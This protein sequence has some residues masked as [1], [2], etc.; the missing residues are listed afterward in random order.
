M[1]FSVPQ[2]NE[3]SDKWTT[4]L[5]RLEAFFEGN[6]VTDAVQ[7]RALLVSALSSKTIEV[8]QASSS[9]T[10]VN[11]LTYTEVVER[12]GTYYAPK[13]KEIAESFKFFKR[14][15]KPDETVPEYF[16]AIR[17]LA[18]TCNFGDIRER[19]LRDR[20]VCGITNEDVRKLLLTKRDLTLQVIQR[21]EDLTTTKRCPSRCSWTQGFP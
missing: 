18:E 15:Q 8:L 11:S 5:T 2:F 16:V 17:R 9:S 1:A 3:G 14:D 13:R 7:K 4:Y 20:I 12:L 21:A 10:A 19:L 6:A